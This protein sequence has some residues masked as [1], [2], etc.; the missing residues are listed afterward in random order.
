MEVY[1]RFK[2]TKKWS[3]F[4]KRDDCFIEIQHMGF[5]LF[6]FWKRHVSAIPLLGCRLEVKMC[7]A[8]NTGNFDTGLDASIF[9]AQQD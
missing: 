1:E 7:C 6:W 5:A 8:N 3:L 2:P 4:G 9:C